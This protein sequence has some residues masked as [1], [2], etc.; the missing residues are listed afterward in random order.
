MRF[1][2][3]L[4]NPLYS[5]LISKREDNQM[6]LPE[7]LPWVIS[8]IPTHLY[9][10]LKYPSIEDASRTFRHETRRAFWYKYTPTVMVESRELPI[11]DMRDQPTVIMTPYGVTKINEQ[12]GL[13]VTAPMQERERVPV[14]TR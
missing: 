9:L 4:L 6:H 13:G 7:H 10:L 2:T 3:Y 5:I 12:N 11:Y 8:G 1:F 14:A